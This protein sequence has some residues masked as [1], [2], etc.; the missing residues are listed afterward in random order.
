MLIG[1]PMGPFEALLG[2]PLEAGTAVYTAA[3]RYARGGVVA[4]GT[5]SKAEE[6]SGTRSRRTLGPGRSRAFWQNNLAAGPFNEVTTAVVRSGKAV[7]LDENS[8]MASVPRPVLTA[9]P[10]PACGPWRCSSSKR[11]RLRAQ[12]SSYGDGTSLQRSVSGTDSP[13][14]GTRGRGERRSDV[15]TRQAA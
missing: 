5:H 10:G 4:L 11:L 1:C 8:L 6:V 13:L 2:H 7:D 12:T 3:R 15:E 14:R 9:Q